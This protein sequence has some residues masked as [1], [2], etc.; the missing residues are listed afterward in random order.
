MGLRRLALTLP[1]GRVAEAESIFTLAGALS[2]SCADAGDTPLLEP[3]PGAAPLWPLVRLTA[4][5]PGGIDPIGLERALAPLAPT[6]P[7]WQDV[8]DE[9]WRPALEQTVQ[10]L[11]IG[12]RLM[13]VPAEWTGSMTDRTVVR[14]AMGLAFGTGEH[15][16][17]ALCLEWLER[18]PLEN[19]RVLDF[20][21]G[22][23]VL[24]ITA[25][26]LGASYAWATDIEPQA[27]TATQRNAELNDVGMSIWLGSPEALPAVR[28]DLVVANIVA[29]TLIESS[30]WIANH[31]APEGRIVLS[32]ILEQ[33][34]RDIEH[35][36]EAHFDHFEFAARS[37]WLRVT[38]KAHAT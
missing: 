5:L 21:C 14:L 28:A 24:A 6:T 8:A 34:R 2:V 29:R 13:L 37:G 4:L 7:C 25:L 36:F 18:S 26:A 11:P 23:G 17:T 30:A 15:P 20:G 35:A 27:L 3:A 16:T 1:A 12:Q 9:N 22:S 32:G 33:Q 10:P 19:V 38:A 31:L